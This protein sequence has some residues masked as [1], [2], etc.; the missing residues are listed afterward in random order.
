MPITEKTR[1][2]VLHQ[3]RYT[4]SG[5]IVW[6][7]TQKFGRLSFVVKGMRNR[8]AGKHNVFFQPLF[9]LDL[10]IYYKEARRL[11]NI[12]EFSVYFT[13][14]DIYENIKKSCVAIFLGEVLSSVLREESPND[15][16]YRF[17]EE[18]L[19]Y[20]DN[21][22]EDF[23]N[24]HIAFTAGLSSYLGLEPDRRRH[25]ADKYFDLLNGIFVSQ[26]PVH[27]YYA[28]AEISDI[29]AAFFNSSYENVKDIILKGSLRDEVLEILLKYYSLHLPGL[30]KVRSLEILKTVFG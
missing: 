4:D 22:T 20:F 2:I 12:K 24:F 10:E 9:I 29:L 7:Y 23:A 15:N 28:S 3:V 25:I 16:L 14:G 30:K 21:C 19:I 8:K 17:I 6:L 27:D 26:P 11:Q 1:G 13:P 5:I 18:S